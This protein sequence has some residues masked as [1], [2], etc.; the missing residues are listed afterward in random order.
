MSKIESYLGHFTPGLKRS[1]PLSKVLLLCFQ[2][3]NRTG[4][5]L[6]TNATSD[7]KITPTA[8]ATIAAVADKDNNEDSNSNSEDLAEQN[9]NNK[10]LS[11]ERSVMYFITYLI[12]LKV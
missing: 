11:P 1:A 7:I 10:E 8:T 3:Q 5:R 9:T 12:F 4:G 2:T 6:P